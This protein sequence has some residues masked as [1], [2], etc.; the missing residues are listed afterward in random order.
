MKLRTVLFAMVLSRLLIPALLS[1]QNAAKETGSLPENKAPVAVPTTAQAAPTQAQAAQA[2]PATTPSG[3]PDNDYWQKHDQLMLSDFPWLAKF[4][5][6]DLKL[7]PPAAGEDR[8]VFMGDSITQG[9]HLDGSFP[10][11]PYINR[12]ISG[13]TTPQMVLRFHQDVIALKPKVVVIL[14]GI[15]DIAGNTGPMTPDETEDNLSA[16]AEIAKANKIKVVLCSVLPAYDFPWSP[17]QYPA[18]KVVEL[19]DWIKA[20]ASEKSYIYVDFYSPMKDDRGGLPPTLS[21]D[22]VHPLP[23]G[24]AIMAPLV[25]AAIEKA[26]K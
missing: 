7:G 12:G 14:A 17:G 21:R 13:Q 15:N 11:K 9:W 6:D 19:N 4:K 20:H 1:A 16:M 23:A 2:A 26:S 5:E 10:G 24:Y 8:V 25:Q 18:H 22:G 3:H